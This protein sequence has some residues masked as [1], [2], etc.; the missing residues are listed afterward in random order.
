MK[1]VT[2]EITTPSG[3]ARRIGALNDQWVIDLNAAYALYLAETRDPG[4]AQPQLGIGEGEVPQP[5]EHQQR[6]RG[7]ERQDHVHGGAVARG[8][9]RWRRAARRS[10]ATN[11]TGVED[12]RL[13]A[14]RVKIIVCVDYPH[15]PGRAGR[16]SV[17]PRTTMSQLD[18]ECGVAA[19]YHLPHGGVSP[20][21]P[22]QGPDEISR[23]MP[24]MHRQ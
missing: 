14:G 15:H 1:L 12:R 9:K 2:F 23:L 3:P 5:E 11:I 8:R 10:G 4:Q 21:C 20:L 6:H 7:A 16:E 18:E 17:G 24:R 22:E 13:V 19:I